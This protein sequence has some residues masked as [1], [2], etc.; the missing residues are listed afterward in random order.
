LSYFQPGYLYDVG[1]SLAC[2][3][4]AI[5]AAEPVADERPLVVPLEDQLL[6][7]L[8]EYA[9]DPGVLH[10]ASSPRRRAAKEDP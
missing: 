6:H 1:I 9:N 8:R 10:Q 3:L 2:Y 7:Q 5:G 4:L